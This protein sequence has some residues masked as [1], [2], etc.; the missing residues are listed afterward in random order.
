MLISQQISFFLLRYADRNITD[1]EVSSSSCGVGASRGSLTDDNLNRGQTTSGYESSSR[2]LTDE[3]NNSPVLKTTPKTE[4]EQS[5]LISS[6]KTLTLNSLPPKCAIIDVSSLDYSHDV[7]S[8]DSDQTKLCTK[9]RTTSEICC[10]K[11]KTS[12][13]SEKSDGIDKEQEEIVD[14][15]E[16]WFIDVGVPLEDENDQAAENSVTSSSEIELDEYDEGR[17]WKEDV[18]EKSSF[19]NR[20][21]KSSSKSDFNSVEISFEDSHENPTENSLENFDSNSS[22]ESPYPEVIH[23]TTTRRRSNNSTLRRNRSGN[24]CRRN[25]SRVQRVFKNISR[26]KLTKRFTVD[27]INF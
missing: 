5:L 2:N 25:I 9:L 23:A 19:N 15:Q 4:N 13:S 10:S 8:S 26:K 21:S 18:D 22:E 14:A 6:V 12:T 3:F 7:V 1:N 27:F 20:A 11:S 24:S 16:V 17:A